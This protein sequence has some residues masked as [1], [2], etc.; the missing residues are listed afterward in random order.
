MFLFVFGWFIY[1]LLEGQAQDDAVEDMLVQSQMIEE[2][3]DKFGFKD[4]KSSYP[5][6]VFEGKKILAKSKDFKVKV[7]DRYLQEEDV[8]PLEMDSEAILSFKNEKYTILI[9][10]KIDGDLKEILSYLLALEGVLFILLVFLVNNLLNKIINPIKNINKIAKEITIEDFKSHIPPI[11]QKNE[12]SEL[13]H[14]FNEMIDRLKIE[15]E[16][17]ERFNSDVSHELKSP[18]TVINAQ[19]ELIQ[20]KKR[21]S[22]YCEKSLSLIQEESEK[23][24]SI[25][26]HMLSLTNANSKVEFE[27][28][29]F[30]AILMDTIETLTPQA[31]K[32]HINLELKVFKKAIKKAN[33]SLIYAIFTNILQNAIK[34]SDGEK[35]IQISL[36]EKDKIHFKVKDEGI[37]ISDEDID[38]ITHRFYRVDKSR[39]K[40]IKGFG[41]GLSIVQNAVNIHNGE[42]KISSK[43]NKGTEVEVII[44]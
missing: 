3:M 37:G 5:Y 34:Y 12:I 14:T 13:I 6:A 33:K 36:Y 10:G 2:H 21:D 15:V 26:N 39:N 28:C 40:A 27:L 19:I 24:N 7:E 35:N 9:L 1:Y 29:D 25:V 41:L 23:I 8:Y 44:P 31:N 16:K 17:I 32:E 42:L 18:L 4:I 30:N 38:K 43:L 20:R 22:E 11:K